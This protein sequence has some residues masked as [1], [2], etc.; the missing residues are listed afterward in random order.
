MTTPALATATSVATAID[1]S[2]LATS[3][4]E[5]ITISSINKL[6]SSDSNSTLSLANLGKLLLIFSID[7]VKKLLL[8]FIKEVRTLVAELFTQLKGVISSAARVVSSYRWMQFLSSVWSKI[9]NKFF[10][11]APESAFASSDELPMVVHDVETSNMV[12][13]DVDIPST[14]FY[15]MMEYATSAPGR[16]GYH[17]SLKTMKL[18]DFKSREVTASIQNLSLVNDDL[19]VKFAT[20]TE[21]QLSSGVCTVKGVTD[22]YDPE[23]VPPGSFFWVMPEKYRPKVMEML[24]WIKKNIVSEKVQPSGTRVYSSNQGSSQRGTHLT[25]RDLFF[26]GMDVKKTGTTGALFLECSFSWS[27]EVGAHAQAFNKNSHV[28]FSTIRVFAPAGTVGENFWSPGTAF[29]IMYT[30][31]YAFYP[32]DATVF[33]IYFYMFMQEY[34]ASGKT[35]KSAGCVFNQNCL[36]FLARSSLLFIN[37][38]LPECERI[39]DYHTNSRDLERAIEC[40]V[41]SNF[42]YAVEGGILTESKIDLT[43]G[44]PSVSPPTTRSSQKIILSSPSIP[45][46]GLNAAFET[47]LDT[48]VKN[49]NSTGKPIDVSQ[50]TIEWDEVKKERPNPEYVKYKKM[51]DMLAPGDKGVHVEVIKTLGAPPSETIEDIAHVP[52]VSVLPTS[53]ISFKPLNTLYLRE[54]DYKKLCAS[55]DNFNG[56]RD[57]FT[58]FGIPRKLVFLLHGEP[59]TGKSTTITAIASALNRELFFLDLRGVTKNAELGHMFEYAAKN[60]SKGAIIVLEDIDATL[61]DVVRRRSSS[62]SDDESLTSTLSS[63]SSDL[64]LSYFLNLLD[65]MLCHDGTC[66]VMTT[67]RKSYLDPAIYR[68][69]RVTVDIEYKKCDHF[70]IRNIYKRILK[71]DIPEDLLARIP[72]DVFTPATIIFELLNY[73]LDPKSDEEMMA[74]FTVASTT[75]SDDV[76]AI[77]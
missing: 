44:S 70:Q 5:A 52:K 2:K 32:Y 65:G 50:I 19:T 69:G 11:D 42:N 41:P 16:G 27:G 63:S 54:A 74:R 46:E 14:I 10:S 76:H 58:E 53:K 4:I 28:D 12:T 60:V 67:N 1:T 72:E 47:F 40:L 7:E 39:T 17:K 30:L 49:S 36:D 31:M 38:K 37:F 18:L 3:M 68:A 64:T 26:Y 57:V 35:K 56:T 71:K 29:G 24:V 75:P 61:C 23:L 21:I 34:N 59:G 20:D 15:A 66:V 55:I 6:I 51:L 62:P 8:D 9:Y 25:V 43:I 45:R 33:S 13:I 22:G 73:V 77:D 48:F